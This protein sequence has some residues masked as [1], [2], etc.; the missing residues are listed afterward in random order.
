[1]GGSDCSPGVPG[2]ETCN[3]TTGGS[4]GFLDALN[5][6]RKTVQVTTT[7]SQSVTTTTTQTTTLEC[8]WAIP[9]PP[10]GQTFNKDLVN[11]TLST[12]GGAKDPL[13]YLPA[14]AGCTAAAGGWYYDDPNTPAKILTCPDT[15][16]MLKAATDTTVEVQVGCATVPAI[17]R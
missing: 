4:Q 9:Q 7:S 5:T 11:V 1:A 12:G 2:N 6:I 14:E 13:G 15:C 16:T 10:S 8:E 3:V 17:A